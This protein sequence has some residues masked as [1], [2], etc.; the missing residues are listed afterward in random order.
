MSQGATA[1]WQAARCRNA[2]VDRIS[3]QLIGAIHFF[4]VAVSLCCA[5][6]VG[7]SLAY[8]DNMKFTTFDADHDN[9]QAGVNCA[10]MYEGGWWFNACHNGHLNG[11]Y[12]HGFHTNTAHGIIWLHWRG[13]D[14]SLK[15][16]E[17][18]MRPVT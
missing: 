13:H 9:H 8:H 7:N 14:Y 18:K 3:S 15:F 6:F 1:L 4:S 12:L 11:P 17:M 16:T 2:I 5:D 10:A